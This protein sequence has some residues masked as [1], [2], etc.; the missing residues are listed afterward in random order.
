[1]P[2][3]LPWPTLARRAM[4]RRR[5]TLRSI[6]NMLGCDCKAPGR[7][8]VGASQGAVEADMAFS[9]E[10]CR[11]SSAVEFGPIFS[12]DKDLHHLGCD[13]IAAVRLHYKKR[14]S[15][16]VIFI[17]AAPSINV[18]KANQFVRASRR[19]TDA[20]CRHHHIIESSSTNRRS[21]ESN[22]RSSDFPECVRDAK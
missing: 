1:M 3:L 20:V 21:I 16:P 7:V 17:M 15:I 14:R 22:S 6:S 2:L 13:G 19:R 11:P 9:A 5:W 18:P 12:W 8:A 10:P 4:G